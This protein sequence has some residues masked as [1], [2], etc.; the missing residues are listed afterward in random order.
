MKIL[1]ILQ[2]RLDDYKLKSLEIKIQQNY[3][4]LLKIKEVS[5]NFK[6]QHQANVCIGK[7]SFIGD[8]IFLW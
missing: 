4:F 6:N 7:N 8:L 3:K 5:N 1:S 2:K